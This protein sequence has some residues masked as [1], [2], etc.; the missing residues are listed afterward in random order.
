ME[1]IWKASPNFSPGRAGRVPIAI[2]DHITAGLMPGTLSWLLNPKAQASAHYLVT[3]EGEVYQLVKDEDTAWHAGVVNKPSWSG[4]DGTNPNLCTLGIEHEGYNGTLTEA[5]YQ[6]TL[7]LHQRIVKKWS[8]PV[9]P[10]HI[11]GHYRIDSINR[12]NCPGP[13]F[14]WQRLFADLAGLPIVDIVYR[15]QVVQGYIIEDRTWAPVRD[16]AELLGCAVQW[17]EANDTVLLLPAN[18]QK[19][20]NSEIKVV[21]GSGILPAKTFNGRAYTPVRPLAEALGHQVNWDGASNSVT[22]L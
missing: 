12:P 11:I 2:V 4:Y 14:P 6:A 21:I 5:Q 18:I 20:S 15:Q 22:I 3:R 10:D 17:D 16:L 1:I 9:T 13:D 7:W 8:L 19:I